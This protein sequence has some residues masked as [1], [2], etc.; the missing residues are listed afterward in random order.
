MPDIIIVYMGTNDLLNDVPLGDNDGTKVVEEGIVENFSDGY[1]LMLDKL[2]SDYPIAQV[3]CCTLPQIGDWGTEQPFVTFIN[4]SGMTSEDYSK[5]IQI[6]AENKGISVIDLYHCGIEIDNMH[7]MTTDGVHFTPD[8]MK[9]VER[10]MLDGI[11]GTA[12]E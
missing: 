7:E 4:D 2:V 8:G 5:Q 1:C 12:G 6:I 3:Y 9:Y 10:A 11:G